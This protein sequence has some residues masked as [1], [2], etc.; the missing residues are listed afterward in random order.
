MGVLLSR[1]RTKRCCAFIVRILF[2]YVIKQIFAWGGSNDL[3][4]RCVMYRNIYFIQTNLVNSKSSGLESLFQIIKSSNYRGKTY[5][6]LTPKNDY[7]QFFLSYMIYVC[8][9]NWNVSVTRFFNALKQMSRNMGFPTMWYVRPAKAQ[10]SLR[11][12]TIWSEPLQVAWV[13]YEC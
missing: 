12:R 2:A 13:F 3:P 7:F 11:I 8:L 9:R 6:N 10:T 5:N 1:Q 4:D